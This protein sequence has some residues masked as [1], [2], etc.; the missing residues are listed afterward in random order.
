MKTLFHL[1]FADCQSTTKEVLEQLFVPN[2][3]IHFTN[4]DLTDSP[5]AGQLCGVLQG[6]PFIWKH[7]LATQKVHLKERPL[8]S[9]LKWRFPGYVL[10]RSVVDWMTDY[11]VH[12][13]NYLCQTIFSIIGEAQEPIKSPI[14]QIAVFTPV[15]SK[16]PLSVYQDMCSKSRNLCWKNGISL[17]C[18][19]DNTKYK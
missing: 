2:S 12:S 1:T 15:Y 3:T 4:L 6:E 18:K 8:Q 9:G 19:W 7:L 14:D 16:L 17:Y 5:R 11:N 10:T 13:P